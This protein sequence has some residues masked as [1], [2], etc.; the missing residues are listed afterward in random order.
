[1]VERQARDLEVRGSNPV[2]GS[3][4][5]LEFKIYIN[6][7]SEIGVESSSKQLKLRQEETTNQE[8]RKDQVNKRIS[9]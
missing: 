9:E 5:S 3:N 7:K 6:G 4:F 2:P 8:F 1:M